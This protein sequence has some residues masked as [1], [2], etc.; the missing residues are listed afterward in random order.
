MRYAIGDRVL[1]RYEI[2]DFLGAGA[3]AEVYRASEIDTG[4]EVVLKIPHLTTA[5]DLVA[6]NQYRREME[7]ASRLRHPGLQR[8]LSDR[9]D[10]FMVLEY[11]EGQSLRTYLEERGPLPVDQVTAI[12]LQLA[13]TLEYVHKGWYT[14][15]SS[16]KTC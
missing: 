14:A 11:I 4:R 2:R 15:T 13:D 3:S 16:P 1:D 12:G 7:I 10:P 6:F 8:V 5:G 9:S